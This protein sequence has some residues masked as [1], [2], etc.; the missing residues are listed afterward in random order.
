MQIHLFQGYCYQVHKYDLFQGHYIQPKLAF[1]K[2]TILSQGPFLATTQVPFSRKLCAQIIPHLQSLILGDVILFHGFFDLV[3]HLGILKRRTFGS[4]NHQLGL[5]FPFMAAKQVASGRLAGSCFEKLYPLLPLLFQ[6]G[7]LA[8]VLFQGFLF[9]GLFLSSWLFQA[10]LA[11]FTALFFHLFQGCC[12]LLPQ[13]SR[14]EC[15]S[16]ACSSWGLSLPTLFFLNNLGG[17]GCSFGW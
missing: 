9:Q 11:A 6:A 17:E 1:F 7:S 15:P 8:G 2:A 4:L 3:N 10:L 5:H 16:D 12:R 14:P 13:P